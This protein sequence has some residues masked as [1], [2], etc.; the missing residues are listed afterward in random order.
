MNKFKLTAPKK[1]K[2]FLE[3]GGFYYKKEVIIKDS[4]SAHEKLQYIKDGWK[5][6][7]CADPVKTYSPGEMMYPGQKPKL[8]TNQKLGR[9]A[10]IKN[11]CIT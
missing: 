7:E 5:I 11:G 4:L 9:T 2:H 1:T 10:K 8:F 3:L 6:E